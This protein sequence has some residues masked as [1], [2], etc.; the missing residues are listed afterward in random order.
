MEPFDSPCQS[1]LEYECVCD[2]SASDITR[3]NLE[4]ARLRTTQEQPRD[5]TQ[6][7]RQINHY[8]QV[9]YERKDE[10]DW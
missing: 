7:I 2:V 3:K 9:D 5:Y 1:C 8:G 10:Q 4:R 6:I